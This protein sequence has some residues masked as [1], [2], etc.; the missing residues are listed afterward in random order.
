MEELPDIDDVIAEMERMKYKRDHGSPRGTRGRNLENALEEMQRDYDLKY[1]KNNKPFKKGKN[2]S[3]T[4]RLIDM[5][6]SATRSKNLLTQKDPLNFHPLSNQR[7]YQVEY[8]ISPTRS[9]RVMPD[10]EIDYDLATSNPKRFIE[11]V[12]NQKVQQVA[13]EDPNGDTMNPRSTKKCSVI[14]TI[15]KRIATEEGF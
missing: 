13:V 15:N 14:S 1:E 9:Y 10:K 4:K 2:S 11:Q 3:P 12:Y 7:S 6:N 8:T 5:K